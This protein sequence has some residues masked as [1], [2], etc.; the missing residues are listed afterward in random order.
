MYSPPPRKILSL[1]I[2]PV[3]GV[4][5]RLRSVGLFRLYIGF[6]RVLA[7]VCRLGMVTGRLADDPD[8]EEGHE[9]DFVRILSRFC[10]DFVRY[11]WRTSTD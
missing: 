2:I 9:P 5:R 8:L 3:C 11:F 1:V 6:G 4:G 7:I 10:A